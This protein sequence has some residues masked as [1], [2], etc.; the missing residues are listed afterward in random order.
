MSLSGTTRTQ[1]T[2]VHIYTVLLLIMMMLMLVLVL[3]MM[4]MVM[5]VIEMMMPGPGPGPRWRFSSVEK[6]RRWGLGPSRF[7]SVNWWRTSKLDRLRD[8]VGSQKT[9]DLKINFNLL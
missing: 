4:M 6:F 5:V 3:I 2:H 9:L 8:H 7:V 1:F